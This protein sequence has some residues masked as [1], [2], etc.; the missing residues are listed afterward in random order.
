M[1]KIFDDYKKD[2]V[3]LQK[4]YEETIKKVTELTNENTKLKE[5]V[6]VLN[7][8]D[9]AN[10]DLLEQLNELRKKY[11]ELQTASLDSSVIEVEDENEHI[12]LLAK[13]KK[14]GGKR[15]TPAEP[16]RQEP[17]EK[18]KDSLKSAHGAT[19]KPLTK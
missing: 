16:V 6:Q 14:A 1:K 10:E 17:V 4:A 2:V 5:N 18:I 15:V 19:S 12:E 9:V 11:Q 13:Y 3:K 8:H 7:N